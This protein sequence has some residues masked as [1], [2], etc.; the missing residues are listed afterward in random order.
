MPEARGA[1]LRLARLHRL[2]SDQSFGLQAQALDPL[3]LTQQAWRP[4]W[5]TASRALLTDV[6]LLGKPPGDDAASL[7]HVWADQTA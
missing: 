4:P 3:K 1:K 2:E 5:A 7:R 6:E